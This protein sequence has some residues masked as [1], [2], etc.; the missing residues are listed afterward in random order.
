MV[1]L[2]GDILADK[3]NPMKWF[4]HVFILLGIALF[5][6]SAYDEHRGVV[7]ICPPTRIGFLHREQASRKEDPKRFRELMAYEWAT[8][9]IILFA[10]FVMLGICRRID[11]L[12][13]LTP[14]FRGTDALDDLERTLD[15][16]ERRRHRPI[17]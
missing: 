15:N 12:D 4:P 14:E 13:P 3:A 5:G 1:C 11:H 8:A 10:G 7:S 2:K 6:Q 9:T 16:E 17:K